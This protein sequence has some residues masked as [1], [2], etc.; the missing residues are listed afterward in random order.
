[1]GSHL[2]KAHGFLKNETEGTSSQ[3]EE[4]SYVELSS[5]IKIR[6]FISLLLTY[7]MKLDEQGILKSCLSAFSEWKAQPWSTDDVY[8]P[9]VQ[10]RLIQKALRHMEGF[11][12]KEIITQIESG[13]R[14]IFKHNDAIPE[15]VLHLTVDL[16]VN[17][18]VQTLF[19]GDYYA[20][21]IRLSTR[22]M[23]EK[24]SVVDKILAALEEKQNMF[25]IDKKF[26]RALWI[27]ASTYATEAEVQVQ[28]EINMKMGGLFVAEDEEM[29][30]TQLVE[31]NRGN[32]WHL[33]LVMDTNKKKLELQK[34]RFPTGIVVLITTEPL[35]RA[36]MDDDIRI[37]CSMDLNIR[38]QNHLLPWEVF[39]RFVGS[40]RIFSTKTIKRIAVQIVKEC[41]GHL[42]AI[43]LLAKYLKNLKDVKEWVVALDKLSS[44][45]PSYDYQDSNQIGISRVMVNAFIN[46]IWENIDATQEILLKLSLFVHN[47]KIG[48]SD[49]SLISNWA[50]IS[51]G[52]TQE[53]TLNLDELG[54]Y[55][56]QIKELR[57]C[58]VLLQNET[59]DVYLPIEI[60]DII[61]SLHTLNP[62]IIKHD[63]LGLT[64]LPYIGRWHDLI[65]I[66]LMDNKICELPQSL[67]C[68]KL[69]VFSLQG[70]VDL[71][72]IPDS[73][74][75][76]M[77]LLQHLDLSY[78]SVR[79]LPSSVYRLIQLKKFYLRGSDLFMELSPQI[80]KLKNMEELDLDGTLITHL[81]KEIGELI[82]LKSLTLCFDRCHHVLGHDKKG[83]QISN[84]TII[85]AGVLS[86][87]IHLNYL[88]INVDPEDERW[89]ENVNSVFEEIIGLKR[90]E[91]VSIH[92]PKANLLRFI[93][94]HKS[95]N[96]RLV[97]GHHMQRFISR[98]TPELEQKFKRWD[99][100]I[101]FVCGVNVPY[102]VKM[103]L[104]KFKALYLDRH[105][106][107]KS[108][109]DFELRNLSELRLCILAECNEM[110]TIVGGGYSHDG[111]TLP[112]LEFLSVYYM[113][114]L[115]SICER[116]D[117]F[118]HL[119]SIALC[120]C[121]MLT[122][123]FTLDSL[124]NLS[125]LEEIIL[126]DCPKVTTLITHD[127]SENN[128]AIFLPKLR[129][130]SLLY[131]P[132]LVNIFNGFCVGRV[133]EEMIFYYCPKLQSLSQLE[134]S[135]KCLWIIKGESMWWEALKWNV[136][137]WGVVGR[138]SFLELIFSPINEEADLMNEL[139]AHKE[140][141]LNA[142]H[143]DYQ[144]A[145]PRNDDSKLPSN[146]EVVPRRHS[147]ADPLI[148]FTSDE[149]KKITANFRQDRVLGKGRFGLVYKGFISEKIRKGLPTLTVA[150]GVYDMFLYKCIY[151]TRRYPHPNLVQ[152]IGEHFDGSHWVIF[153]Y[154]YMG[155]L[156]SEMLLPMPW[157]I[158]MKIASGAAKGLAFVHE[159][160][161]PFGNFQTSNILLDQ[162]Y[163][164]K[165]SHF[166]FKEQ[167]A[168]DYIITDQHR[169]NKSDDVYNFGVVLLKLLAGRNFHELRP[170]TEQNL[171]EWVLAL[172]KD[173][174]KFLKIIDPKL[175]GDY[176][177]KAVHKVAVLAYRCLNHNP[178]ER[179]LMQD[180]ADSLQHLQ[181]HTE[182]PIRKTY[183]INEVSESY[184]K[185]KYAK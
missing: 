179:P 148:R 70:N 167:H 139:V 20:R 5:M 161:F 46:I 27:D 23:V 107:I 74:F 166:V 18:L 110:E 144:G 22:N 51:L 184:L 137:E 15:V 106:T 112:N 141:E 130:V 138:P 175:N 181:A 134:L 28:E 32:N 90:L 41:H 59:G 34:V 30:S 92:V 62:S 164:A 143:N 45:N 77:P 101:K 35:T 147:A 83:K 151:Y 2:S 180:I 159:M 129:M 9:S 111:S 122:T 44:P 72:D 19:S 127:S 76:H 65:R 155:S 174:E 71:M 133:L 132:E 69:K 25:G 118:I 6:D 120:T 64:E 88:N 177:I 47:I 1:M 121:P 135:S 42:L 104:G 146:P 68:P 162:D 169:I 183:C 114:N 109:S 75:D 58:F 81:P 168:S 50:D 149:I 116:T 97:V 102:V 117:C 176:P 152:L 67:D 89:N 13:E 24:R 153:E 123:V 100:S 31:E 87:F 73:F 56:R 66:E 14:S 84:S 39:C 125:F 165:L 172:L 160:G 36:E 140:I 182:V 26:L 80:G 8:R 43:V 17:Q 38:T 82:K 48:V 136:A 150:V 95:L 145:K 103:N 99:Y 79:D 96:F 128:N 4:V 178:E 115:R 40:S 157:S 86:N 54:E 12:P 156:F 52:Y 49:A 61:K 29:L 108:L 57:D 119:K 16:A 3:K 158:R 60:Y 142:E 105:M 55:R 85:P 91:T 171:A 33:V 131:L 93:P 53:M 78:T 154:V 94:V 126:E 113:K 10:H 163:N 185:M 98:V 11:M 63:A 7:P 21:Y 37:A 170:A 124:S 173:K